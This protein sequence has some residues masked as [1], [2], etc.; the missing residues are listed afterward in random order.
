M[1]SCSTPIGITGTRTLYPASHRTHSHCAQRRLASRGRGRFGGG[2]LRH[3]SRC[4]QRRLASRGRGLEG[5]AGKHCNLEVLNADWHHGD[6]DR[7][8]RTRPRRMADVLNADW[9]HGD[10]DTGAGRLRDRS[11]QVLNA[12]WHHGDEDTQGAAPSERA[13][14][15]STPIGITGT[16]TP[17]SRT[18]NTPRVSAQRRLASRGRG[19]LDQRQQ[20]G[21]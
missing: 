16:R 3:R 20:H 11:P 10:E 9:H 21:R 13:S 7:T 17:G 19:H 8:R 6:E 12:D 5:P 18:A 15:C 14:E 2:H 1:R 4:A